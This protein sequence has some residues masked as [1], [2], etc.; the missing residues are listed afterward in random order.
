MATASNADLSALHAALAR[1]LSERIAG[2]EE[3]EEITDAEGNVTIKRKVVRASAAELA[4]ARALLK[5][6]AI[7]APP[8]ASGELDDLATALAERAKRRAKP[9]AIE[10]DGLKRAGI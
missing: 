4:V 9:T 7:T 8:G 2:R 1:D 3:T 10:L 5:D 6:N